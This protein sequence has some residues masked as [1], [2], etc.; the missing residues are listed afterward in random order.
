M[1]PGLCLLGLAASTSAPLSILL[2]VVAATAGLGRP[3][4]FSGAINRRIPSDRR[5]TVL[6]AVSAARTL[7]V[8]MLYPAVGAILDRSLP[9]TLAFLGGLGLVAAAATTA[10]RSAVR[11]AGPAQRRTLTGASTLAAYVGSIGSLTAPLLRLG[12]PTLM[13]SVRR[14]WLGALTDSSTRS[15]ERFAYFMVGH[16]RAGPAAFRAQVSGHTPCRDNARSTAEEKGMGSF[17]LVG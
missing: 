2:I 14:R 8:A 10:P 9:L 5:A 13:T 15:R 4:L 1:A 7:A 12:A 16:F 17:H 3:P 6:S 11:R